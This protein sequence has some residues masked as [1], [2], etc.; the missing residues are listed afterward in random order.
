LFIFY[1]GILENYIKELI[2]VCKLPFDEIT[3]NFK[4]IWFGNNGL[5]VSNFK[6]IID[7]RQESIVL[8]IKNNTLEIKGSE[9]KI[10]QINKGEMVVI[11]KI[12]YV[13]LGVNN[14]VKK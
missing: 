10:S 14:E 4:L 12:N 2:N 9:L 3:K 8:S 1:G 6:K 5:Y 13:A 11:G 7:Y